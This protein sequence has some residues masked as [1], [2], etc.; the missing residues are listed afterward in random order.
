[1]QR[2]TFA[3]AET[4]SDTELAAGVTTTPLGLIEAMLLIE[5]L[6]SRPNHTDLGVHSWYGKITMS[7]PMEISRTF[8]LTVDQW[9]TATVAMNRNTLGRM[10]DMGLRSLVSDDMIVAILV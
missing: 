6:G 10:L 1:M 8:T 4:N 7:G 9:G 3:R 5:E 2:F